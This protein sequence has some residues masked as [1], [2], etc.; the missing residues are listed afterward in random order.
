MQLAVLVKLKRAQ[1]SMALVFIPWK[2]SLE[3]AIFEVR[4]IILENRV[5]RAALPL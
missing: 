1:Q 2:P 5:H 4:K 3:Q